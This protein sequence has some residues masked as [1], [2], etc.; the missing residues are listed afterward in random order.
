MPRGQCLDKQITRGLSG[1]VA[2]VVSRANQR[3]HVQRSDRAAECISQRRSRDRVPQDRL[4]RMEDAIKISARGIDLLYAL[5]IVRLDREDPSGSTSQ[6][7]RQRSGL[8]VR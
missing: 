5:I 2:F 1:H 3:G 4:V 6:Q 8:R 7:A